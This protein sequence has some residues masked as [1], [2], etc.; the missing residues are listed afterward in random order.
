[1]FVLM[2]K[3]YGGCAS[4]NTRMAGILASEG[5]DVSVA[6][7]SWEA[8]KVDFKADGSLRDI[9]VL[10][11]T[12]EDWREVFTML[13][14]VPYSAMLDGM[15]LATNLTD[16]RMLF[17]PEGPRALLSFHVG[18]IEMTCHFFDERQIEFD[19]DPKGLREEDLSE[20][21][22]FMTRLGNRTRKPVV[23]A[24]ENA[25][26]CP[27]FVTMPREGSSSTCP[28]DG[29]RRPLPQPIG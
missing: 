4:S 29:G 15:S 23:L 20:V 17:A 9:Y 25:R 10:E 18:R 16:F 3:E 2:L 6:G 27:S 13:T 8:C 12:L 21:L 22:A 11:A 24:P 1:V 5:D 28:H 14:E 19:F 26:R 7:L